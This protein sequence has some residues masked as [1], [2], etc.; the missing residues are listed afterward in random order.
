MNNG[1]LHLID[2]SQK[3]PGGTL[4]RSVEFFVSE[5]EMYC[6]T[7]GSTY[8]FEVFPGWVKNIVIADME[9]HPSKIERLVMWGLKDLDSQMRQY[10]FC[11]YGGHDDNPDICEDGT[12]QPS[13]YVD[14]GLRCGKCEHEGFLCNSLQLPN[15]VLTDQEIKTLIMIGNNAIDKEIADALCVSDFTIRYYKDQ[16][17]KKAGFVNERK[18]A[19]V[20]LAYKLGLVK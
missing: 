18:T 8:A 6:R 4:G 15:G 10:L 20:G 16:I 2:H 7:G 1:K 14:C 17:M 13:E 9:K 3:L 12:M 19:L 11:L 5:G